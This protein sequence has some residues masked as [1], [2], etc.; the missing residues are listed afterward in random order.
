MIIAVNYAD[1]K[2]KRAQKLNSKTARQY[3]A[4]KVIEY[5]PEDIDKDFFEKNK[6]ILSNSRGGGYY[7]W[8]PYIY[9]KAYDELSDG[10]YLIYTD[11]GSIYV[12]KIQY[13]IDC[14]EKENVNI[15]VFS[16]Q[17]EMV[18]RK[19][20]KRDALILTGCD[21]PKYTETPQ[22]IATYMVYKKSEDVK[23][24][25]DEVLKYAQDIRIISDNPNVLGQPNYDGFI[26]HRHDQAII[27]LI[28]KKRN[29]KRFRDPSQFGLINHYE[30]KVETRSTYPQIVDSHRF[31]AGSVGE[32]RFRRTKPIMAITK[33]YNRI[34]NKLFSRR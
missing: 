26:S 22:S 2:F 3:G 29:I 18:E 16:L 9:R 24:F 30:A 25:L 34:K 4:D 19:Y 23:D 6:E 8:K 1:K 27:S 7:L 20:N 17:N 28:S 5:G 33:N 14:M 11:A 15:M 12:N 10:D 32:I 31:N 13:L 21:S